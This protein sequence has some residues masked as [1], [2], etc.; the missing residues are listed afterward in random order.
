[1]ILRLDPAGGDFAAQPLGRRGGGVETNKLAP[2]RFKRRRDA[3][4]AVD[5]RNLGFPPLAR[6]I[7]GAQARE[8]LL[9]IGRLL[10]RLPAG[11]GAAVCAIR[12]KADLGGGRVCG[13][14]AGTLPAHGQ[15][16]GGP[17]PRHALVPIANGDLSRKSARFAQSER[18]RLLTRCHGNGFSMRVPVALKRAAT[19]TFCREL[20]STSRSRS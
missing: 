9:R 11:G 7:A 18:K 15:G 5:Q 19:K 2:G 1:M 14:S 16:G 3:V 8:R 6:T 17:P 10:S 12:R 13:S 4:K 20:S